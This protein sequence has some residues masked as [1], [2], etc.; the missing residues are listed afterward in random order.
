VAEQDRRLA[1]IIETLRS[2]PAL[3]RLAATIAQPKDHTLDPL[4]VA[5]EDVFRGT[6]ADIKQRQ[7]FYLPTLADVNAGTP[8]RP[9]LDIG[10]GRG[11]FLELLKEEGLT[12]RGVDANVTMASLCQ[13]MGLDAVVDDAVS[14]LSRQE[15]GSLGAVTGFHIV[16]HLPFATMVRLFDEALRALA[17]GGAMIFETP[18]PANV[19]VGSYTFYMDPTHIRPLPGQMM[20]MIATARGFDPAAVVELH[21]MDKR[22]KGG[23]PVL[24]EELDALFHGPQDY[25]LIARKP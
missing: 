20:V 12:A 10:C 16:E 9:I 19:I 22:F 23:D 13:D 25:A 11:E 24:R 17:P 1:A 15:S 21:P 5:F 14:Y 18:N 8:A 3:G 6:R 7:R 2:E 4:Y